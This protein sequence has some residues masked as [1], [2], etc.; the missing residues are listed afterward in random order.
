MI[1][2]KIPKEEISALENNDS[3]SLEFE[4]EEIIGPPILKESSFLFECEFCEHSFHSKNMLKKHITDVHEKRL[5]SKIN[6]QKC[7]LLCSISK[8]QM[9]ER[10]SQTIHNCKQPCLIYHARF[11]FVK[12]KSQ[13]IFERMLNFGST[14][15]RECDLND[16]KE[17]DITFHNPSVHPQ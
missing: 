4:D 8:V 1:S 13:E 3:D 17:T 9:K 2:I 16:V 12:Q 5:L 7:K 10:V 15:W 14:I 6:L 11:S